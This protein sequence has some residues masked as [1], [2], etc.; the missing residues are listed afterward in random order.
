[1]RTPETY[2]SHR[3]RNTL[4]GLGLLG[5]AVLLIHGASR[6]HDYEQPQAHEGIS[7]TRNLESIASPGNEEIGGVLVGAAGILA[8]ALPSID[9]RNA[10]RREED[11]D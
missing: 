10:R 6:N 1:M 5:G 8:I 2:S 9:A 11:L 4:G 3:L 7:I